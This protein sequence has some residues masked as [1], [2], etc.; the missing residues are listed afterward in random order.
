LDLPAAAGAH[1]TPKLLLIRPSSVRGLLLE[2]A[3]R[4]KLTLSGD[5]IFHGGSTEGA[6]QLV[7]QVRDAHVETQRFHLGATEVR[8]EAGALETAPEVTFFC[9]VTQARQPDIQTRRTEQIQKASD[10]HRAAHWHD[11][12]ALSVKISTT[13]LGERFQ[14]ELVADPFNK[15]NRTH[16]NAGGQLESLLVVHAPSLAAQKAVLRRFRP[17]DEVQRMTAWCA[18]GVRRAAP[19]SKLRAGD[20]KI[21]GASRCRRGR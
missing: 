21:V 12:N 11:G 2:S 17:S 3:E 9:G 6:D 20:P 7:L 19:E 10:V 16:V 1:E 14:R 15:H 8:A 4:S 13:A 18:M 5:D